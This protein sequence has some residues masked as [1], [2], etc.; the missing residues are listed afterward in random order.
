MQTSDILALFDEQERR[1]G[2]HPMY[3]REEAGDV[4]RHVTHQPE[5]LSYVA[6][7]RL[8]AVTATAA[9]QAQITYF[10]TL[11]R[12]GFEWKAY[13]HDT[14][15]DLPDRLVALGFRP[16]EPEPL[17]VLPL[18]DLP[19][20][21]QRIGDADVRRLTDPAKIDDVVSVETAVWGGNFDWLKTQLTTYLTDHPDFVSL[22]V[23]YVDGQPASA[24]WSYYPAGSQFVALMGGATLAEQRGRGLYTALVAAR[25]Q[26]A[27]Q[28][29]ARF[30][31]VNASEDSRPILEKRG[32]RLLTV[33][34]P[35]SWTV[36][37][38]IRGHSPL[39]PNSRSPFSDT[40]TVLPS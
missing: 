38:E 3:R 39:Y 29:G 19:P 8:T 33:I 32:F 37:E 1:V 11:G 7:S 23:A 34:R 9:I 4:V 35:F 10:Q 18:T 22:Y 27:R 25:A 40:S 36:G 5:R 12:A 28:R 17:L 16:D 24:A 2:V 6:Y 26:E 14:P 13:A 31:W 21:F 20:A 30:L 15:P